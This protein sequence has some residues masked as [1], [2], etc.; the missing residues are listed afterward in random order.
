[1]NRREFIGKSVLKTAAISALPIGGTGRAAA[2]SM[3]TPVTVQKVHDYLRRMGA[4]WI[5]LDSKQTV[6]TVKSGSP[7]MKVKGIATAWM[8]YLDTLKKAHEDG[9][10]LLIVHEPIYYNHLDN[11][12]TGF[13]LKSARRKK[14]F[15]EKTGLAVV[16][17]HDVWDRVA[18]IGICDSWARFL[19]LEKEL[20]RSS[21]P[22][23]TLARLY[24][25]AYEVEPIR[26]GDFAASVAAR[27]AS[28]GHDNVMF[29]GPKDKIVRSVAVGTGACTRFNRMVTEL[30]VDLT[31]C[32]DDGFTFW[33][34]GALAIDM[35]Y[36]VVIASHSSSEEIGMLRMAERLAE[37]FPQVPVKHI[38]E[39]C[40][41]RQIGSDS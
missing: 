40:M 4:K 19:G 33:R 32:S 21:N 24:H 31:V 15:L 36:P 22:D 39:K 8:G 3:D 30:N 27:V 2:R 6:D 23:P 29:I 10:N 9:C 16:R 34:D 18:G 13:A 17:C 38:A 20:H 26:A 5:P 1:M 28:H 12:P 37:V 7:E 35:D 11:D 41:F 14:E 25:V